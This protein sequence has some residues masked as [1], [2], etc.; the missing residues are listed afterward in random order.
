MDA[1]CLFAPPDEFSPI[2]FWFFN[3]APDEDK[4]KEQLRDYVEKGVNGIVLHPRIG[5]PRELA[6]LSEKY[7][8]FVRFIVKTAASLDMKIVLYDEGM[9]P[10]GS[11]HGM[12]VQNNPD[13]AA[14][15]IVLR[16]QA[17]R[18][19]VLAKLPDGRYLI[20][21]FTQG[22][23]RGI[24][25][26]EDDGEA[27]APAAADILNPRAVELFIRLTHDRYY[28]N[29]KEY[30]GNT[31]IAFFTDEPCA[32]G[33]NAGGF[34]EWAEGMEIEIE[35]QGGHLEELAALFEGKE[36]TTTKIYHKLVKKHLRESFYVPI[37]Q[38]CESHGIA[39]MGHPAESDDVEEA[40]YF[41][42][43]GQDL[44]LRRVEPKTG[45]IRESDS[46][47][48]KLSAD[49]ARHLGRRRNMNE[50]FG[51]CSR[52]NIPWYFTGGDM[53]WYIDWLGIRGVNLFVP[54]AFY[55]SVDGKR[56][57]ERPPDVGPHNIWWK[58]YRFFSDYM[59][60]L[61]FLMT[62]SIN[63]A[64]VAVLCD[65]NC[66]PY[67]EVAPLYEHQVEFNYLPVQLLDQCRAE[68]G[69]LFIREYRYDVILDVIGMIKEKDVR[70]QKW[71]G[72]EIHRSV[73]DILVL[74]DK[75]D[76]GDGKSL[77]PVLCIGSDKKPE[78][79][80][81]LRVTRFNK[82][83]TDCWLLSN[84]GRTPID[85]HIKLTEPSDALVTVID[86]WEGI[87]LGTY[88]E[89]ENGFPLI[90]NPLETKLFTTACSHR[91]AEDKILSDDFLGDWTNCFTLSK[92]RDNQAEYI[93]RYGADSISPGGC[94]KV[95]GEEMAECWCNDEFVGVSFWNDHYFNVGSYLKKG[96]NEIKLLMTGNAA[97]IYAGAEIFYG[98]Y[99]E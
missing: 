22:T 15:G 73:E 3:D 21:D 49:I 37:S 34:R 41:Q 17:D 8:E 62:D 95:R 67:L 97:N 56:S 4:V 36:N 65:N 89:T 76:A 91:T 31:I 94:F 63:C 29:L 18:G 84:E 25:F 7:F 72:V 79:Q 32:L 78:L 71:Q 60:R 61:S 99:Q 50:C 85:T 14:K 46:V 87:S 69:A 58:H 9:Y 43:P 86:L 5:L 93:Y 80:P 42:I 26:G 23:I 39:L 57:G 59:K 47:H 38:W 81:S 19:E 24:H 16:E 88:E 1:I 48:A 98:L 27:G 96:E 10:S 33:R 53:K 70:A 54:H 77:R 55:Y 30:F 6:Y 11:A 74:A 52:N 64:R 35:A 75:Q 66:V 68:D 40:M 92:K 13:F 90:L 45:G 83:G 28:E 12:V 51:V 20:K 44:I 82:D 2:P